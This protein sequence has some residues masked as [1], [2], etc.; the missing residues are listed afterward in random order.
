MNSQEQFDSHPHRQEGRT[1]SL[2][3]IELE[4][5]DGRRI[6]CYADNLSHGGVFAHTG[7]EISAKVPLGAKG[8]CRIFMAAEYFFHGGD[9]LEAPFEVIHAEPKGLGLHFRG[10]HEQLDLL[11]TKLEEGKA[12]KTPM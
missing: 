7:E 5:Q 4:F 2:K 11:L 9:Y 6:H 10:A 12:A 8:A 3:E 1:F